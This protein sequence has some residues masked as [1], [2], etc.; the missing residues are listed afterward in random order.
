MVQTVVAL[1]R[2]KLRPP[3][4]SFFQIN[5]VMTIKYIRTVELLESI[6]RRENIRGEK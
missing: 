1:M 6:Y 4:V 2:L 5:S 3:K